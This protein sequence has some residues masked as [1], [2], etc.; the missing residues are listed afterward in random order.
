MPE[1]TLPLLH[2]VPAFV[3]PEFKE[4][5][6]RRG[7]VHDRVA[8]FS[9]RLE[10]GPIEALQS[11]VGRQRRSEWLRQTC[12]PPRDKASS[13][14]EHY[15]NDETTLEFIS[16]EAE[17]SRICIWAGSSVT[18]QLWFGRLLSHLMM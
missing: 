5:L 18:E 8:G 16:S 17:S 9:E 4:F 15:Q 7:S 1:K 6:L 13:I 2:V 14:P 11:K 10:A 3:S 12:F